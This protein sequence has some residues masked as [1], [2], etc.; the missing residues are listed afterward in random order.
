MLLEASGI[1]SDE[2]SIDRTPSA[3]IY[4]AALDDD[5]KW[6][7]GEPQAEADIYPII[8]R[9]AAAKPQGV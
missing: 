5:M 2:L 1:P 7:R 8:L 4:N 3:S 9:G 6:G